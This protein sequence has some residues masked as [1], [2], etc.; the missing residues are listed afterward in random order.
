MRFLFVMDPLAGVSVTADTTF[1][2]MLAAQERGHE[3]WYCTVADLWVKDG[4]AHARAARASVRAVQGE[5]YVLAPAEELPLAAFEAVWMR[6][7]P[8][9]DISYVLATYPLDVAGTLVV[10]HPA[11]LRDA[12]EKMFGTRFPALG[13]RTLVTRS[14][15]R[16][17]AFLAE[18]GG[19]MIVKPLDG[20]GGL[21]V[22]LLRADDPN[23]PSLIELCT[24]TGRQWLMAQEYLP[25]AARGDKRIL[26]LDGEPLGAILRVPPPGEIRGNIHIG[27]SVVATE[28]DHDDRRICD[29]LAPALRAHGLW[30]VGLDVI[31]GKLTEVNVTSPT[32]I[33]ELTR[34]G[35][36]RPTHAVV[37]W[38]EKHPFGRGIDPALIPAAAADS[39][40]S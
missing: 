4:A 37:D 3:P 18:L 34:L 32:G 13:P 6:K 31:G 15:A 16:L 8:P 29:A 23:L 35:G 7:D 25:A 1:A 33:Q 30:F 20:M 9:F 11:A 27:A 40:A 2:L 28:L 26:L 17:R 12:N 36:G 21:G 24:A 14:P 10:N 39:A 5:H 38:L 22:L 19:R